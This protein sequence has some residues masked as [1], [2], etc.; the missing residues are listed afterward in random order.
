MPDIFDF[1]STRVDSDINTDVKESILIPKIPSNYLDVNPVQGTTSKSYMDDLSSRIGKLPD[2]REAYKY[3]TQQEKRYSNPNLQYT[4]Y[5][6]L[7]TDTEDIYGR[8]QSGWDQLG[9]AL[10]K[11]GA[12]ALGTFTSAYLT[13]PS[14]IDLI[15][16][17]KAVEAFT[18]NTMFSSIQDALMA[19]EDKLPNYYTQWERDNPYLSAVS[20]SGFVNFW[21]DKVLKNVGFSL[22]ALGAGIS[23]DA[24]IELATGG[25]LTPIASLALIKQLKNFKSNLFRG[26]SNSVKGAD[27]IEDAISAGKMT[28][29]FSKGLE[30]SAL[31]E[32]GTIGR[33]A[34]VTYLG[35]QGESFIE[36]YHT[37]LDTKEKYLE[38]LINRK[39]L[40]S[41]SLARAEKLAQD[42]G[43]YTTALNLPIVAASNLLQFSNLLYGKHLFGK[44]NP[45]IKVQFGEKGIEAV[46]DYTLKKG[47]KEWAKETFKDAL[48]EAFEEG[49]QYHISNSVH[50]YYLKR[51]DPN[52][53][54]SLADFI[55]KHVPETVAD[56]QFWEEAF[57]GGLVG[58]LM[59]SPVGFKHFKG[60]ER[61]EE[62]ARQ[63]NNS[64]QRFNGL[65]NQYSF[66][67]DMTN[68]ATEQ[69]AKH[70]A[71]FN[72]THDSLRYGTYDTFINS[73]NDLKTL[74]VQKFNTAFQTDFQTE[75][76]KNSHIES[77]IQ[78]SV[79]MK[80][81]I[82]KVNRVFRDNPYQSNFLIKRIKDA[83][84]PK[85]EIELNSIQEKLFDDFR[86]VVARNESLLR[87]TQGRI[88]NHQ[89]NLKSL[90]IKDESIE[91]LRNITRD[92]T[93]FKSYQ[94][95]KKAQLKDLKRQVQYYESLTQAD[96]PLSGVNPKEELK[97]AQEVLAKT[98]AY[99]E[100]IETISQTITELE[101]KKGKGEDIQGLKEL[102]QMLLGEVLMEETSEEQRDRFVKTLEEQKKEAEKLQQ[103]A[104]EED[105][106]KEEQ[107]DLQSEQ[108][109]TAEELIDIN[110][111]AAQES[112]PEDEK[113]PVVEPI[114]DPNAWLA[115]YKIGDKTEKGREVISIGE[116]HM[117]TQDSKGNQYRVTKENGKFKE[118]PLDITGEI[119]VPLVESNVEQS[120]ETSGTEET[121]EDV[122]EVQEV[123]EVQ[124]P[125]TTQV[126]T[127]L[128][129][130]TEEFS[131]EE[132]FNHPNTLWISKGMSLVSGAKIFEN[133][134]GKVRIRKIIK[135]K[136]GVDISKNRSS[137]F[138]TTPED[139]SNF[140]VRP[141][142]VFVQVLRQDEIPASKTDLTQLEETVQENEQLKSFLKKDYDRLKDVFQSQINRG[143]FDLTC[144]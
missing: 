49:A 119:D 29:N 64:Y 34:A 80:Q 32:I 25:T 19:L 116:D 99:L 81:D 53:K 14:T 31:K 6:I 104:S 137:G 63:L 90:G 20:P 98:E 82:S 40:N 50:D 18:E 7:G 87:K 101:K 128:Q 111:Q 124:Q 28:G 103:V 122:E 60:K 94:K 140:Y 4:P 121:V 12:N 113:E 135:V 139:L 130:G 69:I 143:K 27:R 17:G 112:I 47:V 78:E 72:I 134:Q 84:S 26:F 108:P 9:N 144:K 43:R 52:F 86:E 68:P 38:D 91:Y 118:E 89:E 131:K 114:V 106:L 57:I 44:T 65:V 75:Q 33:F 62:V 22:G 129:L 2:N 41:E 5:N 88:L 54:Q 8:F 105:A 102:K 10:L 123:Q 67:L 100:R 48:G 61:A 58:V 35:A 74:D 110:Q 133:S 115:K 83:F 93:G 109:K 46:S 138:A 66:A 59:G 1:L 97:K 71:L 96:T 24:L 142:A 141:D 76:E 42:A 136:D 56:D 15:R 127:K 126:Q 16:S 45:Y 23:Q 70:D 79:Q 39:E 73:L 85:T 95:F 51:F 117:I 3:T 21:G 120:L 92:S 55:I 30:V 37:Y 11:T 132:I 125:V 13:I 107:Q 77:L 36:G